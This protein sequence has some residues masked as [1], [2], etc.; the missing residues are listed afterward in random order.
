MTGAVIYG[1]EILDGSGLKKIVYNA[2]LYGY[3]EKYIVSG[4]RV[5]Q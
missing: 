1:R 2:V 3:S 5:G 4:F